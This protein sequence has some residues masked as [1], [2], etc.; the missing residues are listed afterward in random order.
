[1]TDRDPYQ[2]QLAALKS[3]PFRRAKTTVARAAF[4]VDLIAKWD[5]TALGDW[6]DA[7]AVAAMRQ[8]VQS[9][10][11]TVLLAKVLWAVDSRRAAEIGKIAEKFQS[12]SGPQLVKDIT[13]YGGI[14]RVSKA[15]YTPPKRPRITRAE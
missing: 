11:P 1:M 13:D 10:K 7:V 9:R 2:P 12:R 6:R 5:T 15:D 14:K 8:G 4:V 3:G